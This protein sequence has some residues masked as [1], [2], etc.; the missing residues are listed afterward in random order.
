MCTKNLG[1]LIIVSVASVFLILLVFDAMI[2]A[3]PTVDSYPVGTLEN[4]QGGTFT[5]HHRFT[6]NQSASGFCL[7]A[8]YWEY[9]NPNT[10]LPDDAY[11]FTLDNYVGYADNGSPVEVTLSN[12]I[13]N[14]SLRSQVFQN[15]NPDP[16]NYSFSVDIRYRLQGPD[17]TLHI[18][19]DNHPLYYTSVRVDELTSDVKYPAPVTVK[20]LSRAVPWISPLPVRAVVMV[21]IMCVIIAIYVLKKRPI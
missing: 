16:N 11:N 12:D 14:G 2:F 1:L 17:G 9:V 7:I 20:V 18:V 19:W 6:Y 5:L 15:L 21:A 4:I 10:G 3:A 8:V 13:D